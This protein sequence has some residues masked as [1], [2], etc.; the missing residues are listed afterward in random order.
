ML[1]SHTAELAI[2]A[3]LYL[4]LQPPGKL[5]TV[6]AI[7]AGTGLPK[8]YLAK[9]LRKL[10]EAGLVRSFR[11]P[12]GGIELGRAPEEI[13]LWKLVS[14]VDG[15]ENFGECVLGAKVCS[16]GKPCPLHEQW[17]PLR[18]NMKRM[19][20]ETTLATMAKTLHGRGKSHG[21]SAVP[22]GS[23]L[24]RSHSGEGEKRHAS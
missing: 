15:S 21:K 17:K 20:D 6:Q 10:D 8:S 23:S 22:G 12:G 18:E 3:A 14:A 13:S 2:R 19:L 1:Y 16:E 4:A 5:S 11:G 24:S 9:I 7:A